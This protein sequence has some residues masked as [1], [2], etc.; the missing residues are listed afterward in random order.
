MWLGFF[1]CFRKY[2]PNGNWPVYLGSNTI[3]CQEPSVKTILSGD[4]QNWSTSY[5]NILKQLPA[6]KLFII[7]EDLYLASAI[8]KNDFSSIIEFMFDKDANHIR[9]WASPAPDIATDNPLIGE[10]LKGAPYRSTVCGFW[11]RKYLIDLLIDGESPWNFEIM[12]SYRTSYSDG[13][14]ATKKP[15]CEYKNMIEK[16]YWIP[17]SLNWAKT[18]NIS[19]NSSIRP[20]LKGTGQI[21]SLLQIFYFSLIANKISWKARIKLMNKLRKALITY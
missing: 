15:I 2:F 19:I 18:N 13:F 21:V 20:I 7:L 3:P 8:N 14:F 1:E 4:D 11:D 5:K 10:C 12:G 17:D 6:R 9:Y 16:G